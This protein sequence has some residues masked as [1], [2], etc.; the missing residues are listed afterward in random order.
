MLTFDPAYISR[1]WLVRDYLPQIA[2][3]DEARFPPLRCVAE[4]L[5]GAESCRSRSRTTAPTASSARGGSA[6]SRISRTRSVRTSRPSRCSIAA[7]VWPRRSSGSS[8]M[9]PTAPGPERNAELLAHDE[10]DFGYRLLVAGGKP[11]W[12]RPRYQT[13]ARARSD[14]RL[15]AEQPPGCVLG[16]PPGGVRRACARGDRDSWPCAAGS[17]AGSR[18]SARRAGPCRAC[19]RS[20]PWRSRPARRGGRARRRGGR[21]R[22]RG[23]RR[24][25][26]AHRARRPRPRARSRMPRTCR[27]RRADRRG[28][29]RRPRPALGRTPPGWRRRASAGGARGS[30]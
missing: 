22:P 7:A 5:G 19:A 29:R 24:G 11:E 20:R 2:V 21:D 25:P 30:P 26:R 8:A 3:Q 6:R 16:P 4:A 23:R 14:A 9:S 27:R 17:A 18:A 10:A 13:R 28:P 1:Y 15:G 12:R